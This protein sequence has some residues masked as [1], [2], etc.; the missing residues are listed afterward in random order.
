MTEPNIDL[1]P[2]ITALR[3]NIQSLKQQ[4]DSALKPYKDSLDALR[5]QNTVCERCHGE[6]SV[7]RPRA[8]AEDDLDPDDPRD[9]IKCPNCK[10]TGIAPGQEG[11]PTLDILPAI[12]SLRNYV[13]K[14]EGD[15]D[16]KINQCK[17]ALNKIYGANDTCPVCK[18]K[19]KVLIG[20]T[21]G[22]T[23]NPDNPN[24]WK[25]CLKCD[26]MGKV[27][28]EKRCDTHDGHSFVK[29]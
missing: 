19:G 12:E 1:T 29:R 10:G 23:P 8:C 5:K 24:D 11:K 7:L 26:G 15:Y 25:R 28:P 13:N 9:R 18:G 4:R 6:K 21:R 20:T 16:A 2:A 17:D 3:A 27:R 22:F 14:L